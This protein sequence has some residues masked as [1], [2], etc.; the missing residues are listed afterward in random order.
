MKVTTHLFLSASCLLGALVSVTAEAASE[1]PN[2]LFILADDQ[3]YG[4][5]QRHGHPYLQ[6]PN[7]NRLYD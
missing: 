1:Q 6:T 2:I 7:L 4:D 5:I 3:G